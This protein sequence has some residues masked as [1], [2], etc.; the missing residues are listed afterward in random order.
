MATALIYLDGFG[1]TTCDAKVTAV[2]KTE[3]QRIDV[4]L[5]K[6]CFY[7]RGGGQ[8]WENNIGHITITKLKTKKGLT[9]VSYAVE[10]INL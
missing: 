4:Q 1:I 5:D 3:D 7:P 6:T 10:G 2:E 8:D 9:K